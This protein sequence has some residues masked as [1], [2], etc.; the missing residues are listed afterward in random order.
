MKTG[1]V[2]EG[3]GLRGLFTAG[4]LDVM[5]E[6]GLQFDGIIG[7]SAGA[8]FGCNY[9]SH[10]PGRTIRYNKQM[11]GNWRYCSLR[12]WIVTGNLVGADFAYHK[13]PLEID[14]FDNQAFGKDPAEFC[15]VCTDVD[16]GTPVYHRITTFDHEGLEW[17]RASASLP[18]V[19]RVVEVGGRRMLDG[20]ISDSIPLQY[21][22]S[23]GYKRNVVILTQPQGFRKHPTRLMPVFRLCCRRIP[24]VITAMQHRHEMYNAQLDYLH[25]QQLAGNTLVLCPDSAIDIGRTE[26]DVVKM[27][28]V[29]DDGVAYGREHLAEI[30]R[31]VIGRQ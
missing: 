25:S 21:W 3:G 28:Q 4:I 8:T 31:F 22:Q 24:A 17:L 10:Q 14:P 5:M 6:A 26:M 29:Y 12:S 20:G 23:Q 1:L 18:V 27:Q 11:A 2:L 19:S 16:T 30:Q 15:V 9:K 13:L 7:V